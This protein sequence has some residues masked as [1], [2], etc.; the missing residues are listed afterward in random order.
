MAESA[1]TALQ[2]AIKNKENVE[3]KI[4]A[5]ID[6]M[7]GAISS[8]ESPRFKDFWNAKEL[9]LTLF[10]EKLNPGLRSEF[11]KE[12]TSLIEEARRLKEV[13]DEQATFALEQIDLAINAFTESLEEK[14]EKV[15]AIK[16]LSF[17]KSAYH[18]NQN[19]K[20]YDPH[21]RELKFLTS[22]GERL[23]ALRK[24]VLGTE[25][26]IRFKNKILQKLSALGDQIF[27]RRRVL[28]DEI[29][30]QFIEDVK[31]FSDKHF[32]NGASAKGFQLRDEIKAFQEYAKVLTISSTIFQQARKILSAC[33]DKI[34]EGDK[35]RK[36]EYEEKKDL[37]D[38]NAAKIQELIAPL[39]EEKEKLTLDETSKR[40]DAILKEMRETELSFEAIKK[41]KD[42]LHGI[43]REKMA[44]VEEE[45]KK[46]RSI[47]KEKMEQ[48]KKELDDLYADWSQFLESSPEKTLLSEAPSVWEEKLQ[49]LQV[50]EHER[51]PFS[52]LFDQLEDL[53]LVHKEGEL[54]EVT[55]INEDYLE[56]LESALAQRIEFRDRIKMRLELLRKEAGGSSLDFERAIKAQEHVN[57][58]K[59]RLTHAND[60]IAQLESR[61]DEITE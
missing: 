48:R 49:T 1:F 40:V 8:S 55:D 45:A 24:E 7:K 36:K 4:R 27:P 42:L 12:Y 57:R 50:V 15:A 46:R 5:V 52:V 58:E 35:E 18:L 25:M 47:E 13:F 23:K 30:A 43:R 28:I 33:W 59:T 19:H 44:K 9:A 17:P 11:W 6:F 61:I 37:F 51:E 29:S 10:K 32:G 14:E 60:A 26:R 31:R 34:K 41:F 20:L 16:S 2:E 22:L 21:Y 39:E 38:A 54:L 53:N 56:A 3:D